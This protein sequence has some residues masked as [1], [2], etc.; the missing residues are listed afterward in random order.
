M[1]C[2]GNCYISP[3]SSPLRVLTG[4]ENRGGEIAT[5]LMIVAGIVSVVHAFAIRGRLPRPPGETD[6]RSRRNRLAGAPDYTRG[7][8]DTSEVPTEPPPKAPPAAPSEGTSDQHQS[9]GART[10]TGSTD[11]YLPKREKRPNARACHASSVRG[12]PSLSCLPAS[13]TRTRF[14]LLTVGPCCRAFGTRG[15]AT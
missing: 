4:Y 7:C 11:R 8:R 6:T 3:R 14:P 12:R 2:V 5:G 1:D 9:P 10:V 15:T 13:P